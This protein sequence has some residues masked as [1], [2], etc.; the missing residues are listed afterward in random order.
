MRVAMVGTGYV[1]LVSGTCFAEMGAV[2]ACIDNDAAKIKRLRNGQIPI[3]EPG[4]DELVKKNK[5]AGRLT[6]HDNIRQ[7]IAGAD[8]VFIAVGTPTGIYEGQTD[9]S[10]VY[11]AA[12]E[13]ASY[14]QQGTLVVTKSTVPVKTGERIR[15]IISKKN[16]GLK[17]QVASNPEFLREG[18]AIKDFLEPDR[19]IIGVESQTARRKLEKLYAPLLDRNVPILVTDVKTA[20]LTKY[21]ANAFLATKIAFV[22]EVADLCEKTGANIEDVSA[23]MGLDHRIGKDYM[24]PGP[25]YGGSCFPKDTRSL[26]YTANKLGA[27]THIVATVIEANERRKLNMVDKISEAAQG[28][29]RGKKIAVL[30]LAFKANTDDMRDSSSL[31]IIPELLKA[32]AIIRAHDPEAISH[33]RNLLSGNIVW[34]EDKEAALKGADMAVIITEWKEYAQLDLAATKKL[35]KKPLIVDLRN[36][37]TLEEMEKAGFTYV[38]IGRNPVTKIKARK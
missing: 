26:V 8:I 32:G 22:N 31:V 11:A 35:L 3:Y 25:G 30:G 24:K 29:L 13:I 1:G 15:K 21:A 4:L 37:Y 38:S 10:Y 9:L 23:G 27:P 19:I 20:E 34:C 16:K 36:L 18:C 6:F 2:V 12:E 28:A 5:A 7:G 33:A 17:F 14:L